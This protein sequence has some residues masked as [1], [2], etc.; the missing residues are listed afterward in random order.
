VPL[1]AGRLTSPAKEESSD[2][3][4]VHA[5]QGADEVCPL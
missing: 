5:A 4:R 3:E 1:K 2:A